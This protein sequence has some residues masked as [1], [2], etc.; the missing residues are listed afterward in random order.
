MS[1]DRAATDAHMVETSKA[2]ERHSAADG[3]QQDSP[4]M[5]QL[6]LHFNILQVC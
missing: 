2:L 1:W 4:V 5:Q 3:A 6:K